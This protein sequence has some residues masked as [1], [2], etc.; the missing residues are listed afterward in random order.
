MKRSRLLTL[1]SL[2]TLLAIGLCTGWMGTLYTGSRTLHSVRVLGASTTEGDM[3]Q[4]TLLPY[5]LKTGTGE[6]RVN[7]R[8]F[9]LY[10]PQSGKLLAEQDAEVAVPIAS[11]TKLMTAYLVVKHGSLDD[12]LTVS[13]EAVSFGGSTMGL[14]R[15]E[16]ITVENV[17]LGALLISGN[18]AAHALAEHVGGILLNNPGA[19]AEEKTARFVAEMNATAERLGMRQTRYRDPAGLDDEGRGSALDLAKLA[20]QVLPLETIKKMTTTATST[21]YDVRGVIR[22]DL[23]NS[24]RLVADYFYAGVLGGKTGF[25]PGAGHCLVSAAEQNGMQLIAVVLSTYTQTKDASAQES[26]KLLDWG[27][28]NYRLQ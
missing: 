18:D 11:T 26:R 21:V 22:H 16:R 20:H 14:R 25:T 19:P 28:A 13:K 23:R 3:E 1:L 7:A 24:N 5:P 17:L 12:V 10:N 4:P 15:D 8:Y 27:F 9:A 2:L 6:P